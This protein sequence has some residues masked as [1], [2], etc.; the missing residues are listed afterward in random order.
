MLSMV[1]SLWKSQSLK[2]DI[3]NSLEIEINSGED[4]MM[5]ENNNNNENRSNNIIHD[6]RSQLTSSFDDQDYLRM[7]KLV[8]SAFEEFGI[9]LESKISFQQFQDWFKKTQIAIEFLD[10]IKRMSNVVLGLKPS[11]LDDEREIIKEL[12]DKKMIAGDIYYVTSFKWISLWKDSVGFDDGEK[13]T[14]IEVGPIDNAKLLDR[15]IKNKLRQNLMEN[16]DYVLLSEGAWNVLW[17]WYG[18]GPALSRQVINLGDENKPFVELY[19]YHLKV[20]MI[21]STVIQTPVRVLLDYSISKKDTLIEMKKDLCKRLTIDDLENVR[22]WNYYNES[23]PTVLENHLASTLEDAKIVNA[24]KIIVEVKTEEG[25]WPLENFS[26]ASEQLASQPGLV[27]LNNLGN[28]CFL[29]SAIQSLSNTRQL[30][31]YFLTNRYRADINKS[32]RLG[33]QGEV[34]KSYASLIKKLW[35]GDGKDKILASY[36]PRDFKRTIGRFAP[37]FS[38]GQQHD[39][40]EL[41]DFLLNG[42]HEDLNL[43][44][45]KPY[46]ENPNND[47]VPDEELAKLFWEGYL[48]RN[49][50]VIVDLFQGQLKSS[51]ICNQCHYN[52]VTFDP[53]TFLSV[54]L[55]MEEI[56]LFEIIVH[57]YDE[58]QIPIKYSVRISSE[59][60][61]FEIK[62]SISKLCQLK[63]KQILLCEVQRHYVFRELGDLARIKSIQSQ[64]LHAYQITSKSEAIIE[65]EKK[66]KKK[67]KGG[68]VVIRHIPFLHRYLQPLSVYFFA[69]YKAILFGVPVVISIRNQT[70]VRDLYSALGKQLS[71]Y[72]KFIDQSNNDNNNAENNQNWKK[73]FPFRLKFVSKNGETCGICS[74]NKFCLGCELIDDL[75]LQRISSHTTFAIEWDYHL[76]STHFDSSLAKVLFLLF[77]LIINIITIFNND[78]LK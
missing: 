45:E 48:R 51:L 1:S 8:E 71:R 29:N 33:M 30:T 36:A 78:K 50:S 63:P 47:G 73:R 42:L 17:N 32:N 2:M 66:G 15:K 27:G 35:Q 38:G 3:K 52:S 44:K 53:F 20:Y 61:V 12:S 76:L 46:V 57:L 6:S 62:D 58:K 18:G 23:K 26:T 21:K 54:P 4:L 25:F 22:I 55:P 60:L 49:Q 40:Q 10:A 19:P 41:L 70:T 68:G 14:Q 64:I 13:K 5:I 9:P 11:S 67:K 56:C 28:T 74:W 77:Y 72:I 7:E 59:A 43:V 16:H 75:Q 31:E 39:A 24:Q 65:N 69:P 34:A 37:Q